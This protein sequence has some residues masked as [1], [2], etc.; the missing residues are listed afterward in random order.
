VMMRRKFGLVMPPL[1]VQ[2][3][4]ASIPVSP[5]GHARRDTGCRITPAWD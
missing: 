3:R 4:R 1:S 2:Q 5:R